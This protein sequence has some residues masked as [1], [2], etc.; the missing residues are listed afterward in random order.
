MMASSIFTAWAAAWALRFFAW[1]PA[2]VSYGIADLCVPAVVAFTLLHERKVARKGRGL[3]RNQRIAFRDALTPER[4]R[5]LLWGWA[6]HMAHL[7]VD[8]ARIRALD[9]PAVR[10]CSARRSANSSRRLG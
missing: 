1:L 10:E 5:R 7:G 9:G 8:F 6:R 2:W 3:L 4:S